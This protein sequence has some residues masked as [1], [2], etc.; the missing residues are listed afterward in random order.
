MY[1][2]KTEKDILTPDDILKYIKTYH[3][4]TV[5]LFDKLWNYYIGKNPTIIKNTDE[6]RRK[7]S[8]AT[9]NCTPVSYGRKIITTFTGYAYRPRYITY[10]SENEALLAELMTVFDENS[11]H[12][13]TAMNGRNTGIFGLSYELM[14][15]GISKTTG[16]PEVKFTVIDPR[17]MILLY[18]FSIEPEKQIAIRF[19]TVSD[20]LEKVA[21]YYADHTDYYDLK[22][23]KY[24]TGDSLIFTESEQTFFGEV[25][26]VPYYLNQE[27]QSLIESTL[28]LIDDYDAL[29]SGAMNEF[30]RFANA[31]LRLVSM[32]LNPDQLKKLKY[33]RIFEQLKDK[34]AVSFLTKD[35]PT[36]YIQ[37]MTDLIKQQIHTQSH[38]PDLASGVDLSG[39]AIKRTM[40][41]FEN[42]VSSA[43]AE[44]DT[45]LLERI[46]MIL[47]VLKLMS[48]ADG[49]FDEI[50]ISHKRNEPVNLMEFADISL[51]MSQ[52]GLSMESI[53]EIWPDDIFP[54]VEQEM[55][56]Q[57][58]AKGEMMPDVEAVAQRPIQD[59]EQVMDEG[60]NDV[61]S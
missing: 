44:F 2:L 42:V 23:T 52:T 13:K 45:G 16:K 53:I 57:E 39:V 5:P 27:V 4:T 61:N 55:E 35:I 29:V 19:Y 17:E 60:A 40:F 25:P 6:I 7:D 38:V 11:E 1:K 56:R 49:T 54:S 48:R 24:G 32:S 46:R 58:K 8:S 41:D 20:E 10:K 59:E 3:E 30:D 28:P 43:E 21:V 51:K 31:Y 15:M 37:F 22:K 33:S 18:D 50:T 34:E 36:A 47:V 12:I 26:I 9:N 14:Y